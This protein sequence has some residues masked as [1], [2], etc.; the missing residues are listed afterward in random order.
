MRRK[1][2]R[3][4]KLSL[5]RFCPHRPGRIQIIYT[6]IIRS[7]KN[8]L[9]QFLPKA[10]ALDPLWASCRQIVRHARD[11]IPAPILP[12]SRQTQ[13]LFL[14]AILINRTK[15]NLNLGRASL[16]P[17]GQSRPTSFAKSTVAPRRRDVF[18]KRRGWVGCCIT[19]P[20]PGFG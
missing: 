18:T 7:I 15:H 6:K 20:G 14:D 12:S 17:P 19:R 1:K 8:T 13:V 11:E 4:W 3:S 9:L 16:G 5:V 10:T 2:A